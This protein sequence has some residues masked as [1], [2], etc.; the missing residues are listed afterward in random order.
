MAKEYNFEIIHSVHLISSCSDSEYL[1]TVCS[2]YLPQCQ[3]PVQEHNIYTSFG[4][5]Q[6]TGAAG[7]QET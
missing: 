3:P 5:G 1:M 7:Y 4:T 2:P 6:F